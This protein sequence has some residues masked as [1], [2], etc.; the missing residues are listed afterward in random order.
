M[1]AWWG[2]F[3]LGVIWLQRQAALPDWGV[4]CGLVLV[5]CVAILV[6]AWGLRRGASVIADAHGVVARSRACRVLFSARVRSWVGWGALWIAALCAGFGYA[7]WRAETRLA[8]S[9]PSAWEGRDIDVVGSIKGLPSRDEKGA[10]FLF[11]VE[12]A[13]A[14][15]AVFP[16]VIQLS[17]IADDAP[18]PSL[19]PGARWRLSVRLKRPHGNANFGVRDAEA[20]LLA[21]NVRATGYVSTPAHA[22]RLPG[23]ARGVGVT[24]DRWRAALRA[25]IN[26]VLAGAPHRGIVVALAIGAQ[27]EV[28]AADW[29]LMRGTGT[30]HLVAIS[31][32]HIGFV[33]G[34]AAWLAGAVW[35]RSGFIGRNWPLVLPAQVVAVTA[36]ALFAGLHAALAG[37]NVPAQRALWMAGVVALAFISGRNVA[38]SVVLAWAL[39]LVL[40]IDPWAVVSAGFWLSFCAVAAILFAMWGQPRVQDH[41]QRRD[42]EDEGG[43]T[44]TR[45]SRLWSGLCRRIRAFGERL[46]GA[47]HVQFAVTVALAPLTVY[48]FAQIPLIGPLANAFAIP[49]VSLL[50]TP[51]VLAGVALPAPFDVYTFRT[52]HA[53]L[54]LLAT[55]LQMLSGPV[56]TLWRLPQPG[57]WTLA[58]AAVGVL[59]CLA[60]RGWPLRWAAPLTWLPLL[61]PAPAGPPYGSFRLTA[62]DVGQGTSVLVET[63]HHAL[64]FDTGPGPESTHAGE[65][66]VVPF[67]QA[68]GVTALDTLII[69]HADS[70][71]SG[72]AP[73]VLDAIEVRQMV[74]ALAPANPLWLNARQRGADTLPCA[75]GQRWQ[76]DGV[77]F[78]MLWP[79]AG[80]LQGKPNAH[81]CVLRVST[82]PAEVSLPAMA[83]PSDAERMSLAQASVGAGSIQAGNGQTAPPRMTA[84]LTADIEAPTERILLARDREALRAQ[85]LIVPHHG[86][87]TS[88]TEPFLDSIDP[89]VALFQVGYR[90]RFHHPNAGVFERYTAR[91]IELARSDVD[92]AARV[93]VKPAFSPGLNPHIGREGGS[94]VSAEAGPGLNGAALTLE[95]YRDTQRRYWMDR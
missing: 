18:A 2:G 44:T 74:A 60:P 61:M 17:W 48:W 67:L 12:S 23:N 88:S 15:I 91:R 53:L 27:D 79:D 63:A 7:A 24:V 30:S 46:R 38:R 92:G 29:L 70:D 20:G 64:L 11:E 1:R 21:R 8:V 62:L 72:G 36:G 10:R 59:W 6:A 87:K 89:L 58:A 52:A 71:H 78:A 32:L 9:L 93:E 56:W 54:D 77:E 47:A 69:S 43:V 73:A 14:P 90:N 50:V 80:P 55:G 39:G 68:H 86:S 83:N 82:L 13:D 95:R 26:A 42:E 34:L 5:V 4:W 3:A 16:R 65:R 81:C 51:A 45:L 25:R 76:W 57:A 66:V 94:G 31:G 84:L 28:S 37:F 85:V 49:W 33:A 40:L 22:V 35:R 75:A 41:E 19:E